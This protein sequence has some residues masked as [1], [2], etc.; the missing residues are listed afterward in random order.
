MNFK[1]LEKEDISIIKKY[2]IK[3]KTFHSPYSI[4]DI[5]L[6]DGCLYNV[7]WTEY[8]NYLIIS[9]HPLNK[10]KERILMP[11]PYSDLS[12]DNLKEILE[13]YGYKSV[14]YVE[15]DYIKK[16]YDLISKI[17]KI[18][19]N[20]F[21][22]DYIYNT[23]DLAELKGS[24]YSPKRNL[25]NQFEKNYA[26][27]FKIK[28]LDINLVSEILN[29]SKDLTRQTDQKNLDILECEKKAISKIKDIYNS[30]SFTG[31]CVYI[32]EKIKAFAVGSE[33]NNEVCICNFE[34]ADKKI[35]GLYQFVD[36]EFAKILSP[37]YKFI[38]KESDLGKESLRKAKESYHPVKKI[39]SYILEL[40]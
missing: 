22:S 10:E 38:N 14:W 17:F 34:K 27:Y 36:R 12:P 15:E 35:K 5:Y 1:K 23:A 40:K 28:M 9:E 13:N 37:R 18:I 31:L 11:V 25:I 26:G 3:N 30:V 7:F 24:K 20:Y 16:H 39:E 4:S 29:L 21:Y 6:W 32:N 8:K 19:P 2:I 33:L